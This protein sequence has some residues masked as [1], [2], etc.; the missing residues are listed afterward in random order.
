MSFRTAL[1]C[2]ALTCPTIGVGAV[3]NDTGQ[4][5]CYDSGNAATACDAAGV[6]ADAGPNPRQDARFG[7]DAAGMAKTGG[8]AAGFD[9][10]R[11]CLNGDPAGTGTCAA[12]PTPGDANPW[13]CTRDN[14]TGLTWSI[15]S[16]LGLTWAQATDTAGGG[17]IDGYHA[18]GR[19]GFNSGWRNPAMLELLSILHHGAS[20][21]AIDTNYFLVDPTCYWS[22]DVYAPDPTQAWQVSFSGGTITPANQAS[23]CHARLVRST[24]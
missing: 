24:P 4:T 12:N 23:T 16:F 1:V 8:G 19:C 2:L 22:S 18:A 20:N 9:F 5:A 17:P 3:L 21:P 15:D 10:T 7:R 6:G 11:V 14:H 13:A